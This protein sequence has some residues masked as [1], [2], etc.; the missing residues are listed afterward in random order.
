MKDSVFRIDVFSKGKDYRGEALK[1]RLNSYGYAVEKIY[2][3]DSYIVNASLSA[4][5]AEKLSAALTNRVTQQFVID[6]PYGLNNF[7]FALEIGF[8][9]GVT[10]NV[11]H[12]V[13]EIAEDLFK[14]EFDREKSFFSAVTFFIKGTDG[15]SAEMISAELSNPLIN[16][17]KIF[18]KSDY[19]K[20]GGFGVDLPIVHVKE[21]ASA[22]EVKIIDDDEYL[23]KLGKMGIEDERGFRGPLAL[24]LPSMHAVR[25][26]FLKVEK[27]MPRDI[28]LEAIAQTWSEHCK[29]TI[30]SAE[31][32]GEKD[33]VFKKYIRAATMEI[34]KRRG[35]NFCIS[36][37]EDNA[38]GIEFDENYMVSDKVETHNSP[39]ALDPFGGSI[40]GIVGVNRDEMGFGLGALP[41]ANRYGFCLAD[42]EDND[43]IYRSKDKS[44]KMLSPR[45]IMEGVVS[46]VNS[47]G[48]TSGIPTPQGFVYFDKSYKGKPLVFVG[49]VGLLPKKINGKPSHVKKAQNGD[50]IVVAGG[51]V[52]LDGIHGATFSSEALSEGSPAGAVQI[53]DPITQKK[54]SDAIVKEARGMDLYNSITDNGA[55]GIS[56]S[57]AEMAKES[58]GFVVDLEK[59]PLK[60]PGLAPWQ[61]W[62][63]ESQER[64]TFSCSPDKAEKLIDLFKSRGVEATV[65]GTFN[66]S[67]RAIV[68]YKGEVIFDLDMDF[69]H[70]GLPRKILSSVTEKCSNPHPVYS[71][72]EQGTLLKEMLGRL[73]MSSFEFISKQFDHEVL[74][75]SCTKPLQGKG[76]VN[77]NTSVIK[78]LFDSY[79]GVVLSQGMYPSYSDHNPYRMALAS[80]DTAFRNALA[81]GANIDKIAI[82]DNF[83]WCDSLNPSRLGQLKEAAK[84]CYDAAIAYNA[85]FVSGK[86]SMFNDF[87]GYDSSFNE[88]K[89]SALPTLLISS[90]A[91]CDDVRKAQTIDFKA[92]GDAV[93]LIG[94]T[95]KELCGS[96][97]FSYL[98][99]K[100]ICSHGGEVPSTDCAKFLSYY[101]KY[102]EAIRS[103][104]IASSITLETG[105]L[106]FA[107]ARSAMA[108]LIGAEI[109]LSSISAES[110]MRDDEILYSESQGRILCSVRKEKRS[111]F[112]KLLGENAHFIG[113]VKGSKLSVKGVSGKTIIDEEISILHSVYKK[114]LAKF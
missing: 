20:N 19:E 109:D 71:E 73:N 22:D 66:D 56:C 83:C 88:V 111:E 62:V 64:M 61:I 1:K 113:E 2:V 38:G 81:S 41:I 97:Y 69:L 57:V 29:H 31:I 8:L 53:G 23:S 36:I 95:S 102:S 39:S 10:D 13:R 9:P 90:I 47:G 80:I 33:G 60:Y 105:G 76:R 28:E 103:S 43:P 78:P 68:K 30:F 85:P 98:S 112:E 108:G 15:N 18:S 16:R 87:K 72:P 46:G 106:A 44:S 11:A 5:E 79:K 82:L 48:N 75:N 96:E 6:K 35:D 4:E 24:D 3:S 12:T 65:I 59:V 84:G 7:D 25:D 93:Y 17:T 42:P 110:N 40:T 104:L 101:K 70:N 100:G 114:R 77:S 58:G 21:H 86:D 54:M 74:S 55:G 14:K 52:G 50:L 99:E 49:T 34:I 91:V 32:D 92:E 37:F 107:L 51:R 45:R 27:R 63:S 67:S 94:K 89:I 26:Y